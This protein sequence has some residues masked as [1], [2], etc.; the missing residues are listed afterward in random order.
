MME[1]KEHY[2][3]LFS[4]HG[5]SHL[6]AQYSDQESHIK[7]L[8]I[9]CKEYNLHDKEVV[10]FGCGIGTLIECMKN[11]DQKARK[12]TGIEIADNIRQYCKTKYK[13][14]N[15]YKSI[16]EC[17]SLSDVGVISGT[18]NNKN[19]QSEMFWK[20]TLLELSK[21]CKEGIVL[22]MLSSYVDYKDENLYYVDPMIVFKFAKENI[23]PYVKVV[24][25]YALKSHGYPYEFTVVMRKEI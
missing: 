4:E 25:D 2:E 21:I 3:R 9:I 20:K 23:A 13:D 11:K 24:N 1:I 8:E 15:F 6:T 18:F 10:D 19:E 12:Y 22:N 16:N 14:Y 17:K 5:E 7:R